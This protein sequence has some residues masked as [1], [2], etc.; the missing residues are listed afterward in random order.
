MIVRRDLPLGVVAAMI[1]HAAGE[2]SSGNLA[3]NT[4]AV[5]LCVEDEQSLLA[6]SDRLAAAGCVHVTV[7]EPDPPYAGAAMALGLPPQ[8]RASLRPHL[9]RLAL[10]K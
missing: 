1:V 8:D 7:R 3:P 2:S 4:H 5:V 9:K 10:F 6:L